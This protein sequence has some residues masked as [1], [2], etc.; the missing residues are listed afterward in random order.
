MME[1]REQA[2]VTLCLRIAYHVLQHVVRAASRAAS[3]CSRQP[4]A[5]PMKSDTRRSGGARSV[6]IISTGP[7]M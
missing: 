3:R 7:T 1:G 6:F 2:L 5:R 4:R